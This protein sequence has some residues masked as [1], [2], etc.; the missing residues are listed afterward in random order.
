[1]NCMYIISFNSTHHAIESEKILGSKNI[2]FTTIPTPREISASCGISIRFLEDDLE[3][4]IK[5]FSSDNLL[6]KGIFKIIKNEDKSK[7]VEVIK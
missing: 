7:T 1:M 5:I 2:K 4:I 6:Y 3:D